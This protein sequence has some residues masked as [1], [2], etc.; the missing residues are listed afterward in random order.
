MKVIRSGLPTIQE[1]NEGDQPWFTGDT[2]MK[3]GN[4]PW[5][6]GDT[7]MKEGNQPWF[8]GDTGEE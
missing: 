8:T 4:Q 1:R 7:G 6:T 2:G 3:E 5:F